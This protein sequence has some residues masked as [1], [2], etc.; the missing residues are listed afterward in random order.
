M[1]VSVASFS[2]FSSAL[3]PVYSF[4]MDCHVSNKIECRRQTAL[5]EATDLLQCHRLFIFIRYTEF[6]SVVTD[7]KRK[8]YNNMG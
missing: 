7:L 4:V 3:V 1:F 2:S 8:D 6:A 5:A